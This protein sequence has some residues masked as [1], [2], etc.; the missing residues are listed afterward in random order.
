MPKWAKSSSFQAS[1]LIQRGSHL[2]THLFELL[3][4]VGVIHAKAAEEQLVF[5]CGI[6]SLRTMTDR[7][8]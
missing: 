3:W 7:G 8:R 5:G 6:R 4:E 1:V 2:D